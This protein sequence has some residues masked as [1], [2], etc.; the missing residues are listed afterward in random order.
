[1]PAN[2]VVA[3]Q[4]DSSESDRS[5][6]VHHRGDEGGGFVG[7]EGS[8]TQTI[9][10]QELPFTK[11]EIADLMPDSEGTEAIEAYIFSLP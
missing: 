4:R 3:H 1:M 7:T 10:H 5:T 2:S 6:M 9:F 11:K 8:L